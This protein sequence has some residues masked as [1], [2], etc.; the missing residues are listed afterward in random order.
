MY[1][2]NKINIISGN[3]IVMIAVLIINL[4][5]TIMKTQDTYPLLKE[6]L[7]F[8]A[9]VIKYSEILERE[10]K[11]PIALRLLQS[12]M[13]INS[14]LFQAQTALRMED[15]K[16]K[17]EKAK[18]ST[19]EVLY[20]LRQCVKSNYIDEDARIFRMGTRLSNSITTKMAC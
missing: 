17:L 20:W 5:L 1:Y 18:I 8:T 14:F 2:N 12:G 19:E 9:D 3:Q 16:L 7:E 10:H 6:S 11:K 4:I 13:N 15:V